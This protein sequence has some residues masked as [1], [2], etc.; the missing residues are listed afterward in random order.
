MVTGYDYGNLYKIVSYGLHF[1]GVKCA[2]VF[3]NLLVKLYGYFMKPDSKS[4]VN[5]FLYK[6]F[7]YISI[8]I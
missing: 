1:M 3:Q 8:I 7:K 5:I 6:F 4:T 2:A